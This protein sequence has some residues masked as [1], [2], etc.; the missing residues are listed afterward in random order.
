MSAICGDRMDAFTEAIQEK[1]TIES[2]YFV[3]LYCKLTEAGTR[4]RARFLYGLASPA[5]ERKGAP[6]AATSGGDR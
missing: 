4:N 5:G 1:L 2:H 6:H 3:M